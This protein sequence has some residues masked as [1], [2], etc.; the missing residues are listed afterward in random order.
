MGFGILAA[1]VTLLNGDSDS[2]NTY[3]IGGNIWQY[4]L[5]FSGM[6]RRGV[7]FIDW[8]QLTLEAKGMD[9]LSNGLVIMIQ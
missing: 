1:R 6:E 4:E 8:W 3:K 9:V 5:D 2:I 7:L